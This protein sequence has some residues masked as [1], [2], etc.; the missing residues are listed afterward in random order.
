MRK[1]AKFIL[2]PL[3][4]S[5]FIV[6]LLAGSIRL[7]LL[8]RS[9]WKK[10][11]S[12]SGA[13]EQ[14]V[15]QLDQFI[16]KAISSEDLEKLKKEQQAGGLNEKRA[17]ELTKMLSAAGGL[18]ELKENLRGGKMEELMEV[19]I[20]RIFGF[21]KSTQDDL[22]LYLP[23]KD[24]GMPEELLKEL[25]F[26]ALSGEMSVKE[27]F[28]KPSSDGSVGQTMKGLKQVQTVVRIINQVYIIGGLV[29]ALILVAYYFL[30]KG[31]VKRVRGVSWLLL[32]SGALGI[33]LVKA[34]GLG[35]KK[36]LSNLAQLPEMAQGMLGVMIERLMGSMKLSSGIVLGIGVLGVGVMM[37]MV[38]SGKLKV[39][40]KEE[41]SDEEKKK[42]R[43]KGFIVGAIMVVFLGFLAMK[44]IKGI[45]NL[46]KG[47][48]PEVNTEIEIKGGMYASEYGWKM[49]VPDG[50]GSVKVE[51]NKTEMLTVPGKQPGDDGWIY[52]AAEPFKR[53]SEVDEGGFLQGMKQ[54]FLGEGMAKQ[55]PNLSFVEEPV[56]GE[57]EE[58]I[59]YE[60]LFDSDYGDKSLRQ[61]RRYIFS[62]AGGDGWLLYSQ[63]RV[64]E[65]E[66]FKP[67]IMETMNSFEL[68]D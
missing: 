63:A 51:A 49:K 47:K 23:L 64:D 15:D 62:K 12:E 29:L 31:I 67:L 5:G 57:W 46:T 28:D 60:Y 10:A 18:N 55:A 43:K 50:W 4:I 26:D 59:S 33:G 14:M 13:Y 7:S 30:G 19:N 35:V 58:Y 52:V 20:E 56:E 27:F 39:E 40:K 8:S 34:A 3:F 44:A 25:P 24:L 61:F 36:A 1:L 53:R 17:A 42:K 37:Y 16:E 22:S 65:W 48:A 68:V 38:K 9:A 2:N 66:K 21:L 32:I 11:L 45:K 41:L 6:V 54:V